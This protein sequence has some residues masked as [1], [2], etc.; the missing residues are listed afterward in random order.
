MQPFQRQRG[1]RSWLKG[2]Y[3]H[4]VTLLCFTLLLAQPQF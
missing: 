3:L 1:A 4:L 2:V